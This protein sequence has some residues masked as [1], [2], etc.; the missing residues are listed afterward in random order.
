[1][2]INL[3]EAS[4]VLGFPKTFKGAFFFWPLEKHLMCRL[5]LSA[6]FLIMQDI[7][8]VSTINKRIQHPCNT[9]YHTY[10]TF[11]LYNTLPTVSI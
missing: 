9:F 6:M 8:N 1:M 7:L 2:K 4:D 5:D 10:K 11:H 3:L